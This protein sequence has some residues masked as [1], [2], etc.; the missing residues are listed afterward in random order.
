MVA[1]VVPTADDDRIFDACHRDVA[2]TNI[3]DNAPATGVDRRGARFEAQPVVCASKCNVTDGHTVQARISLTTHRDA[4]A[5]ADHV[6]GD[7]NVAA[8]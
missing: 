3:L 4:V 8:E 5:R 6:V 1:T 2:E 7:R